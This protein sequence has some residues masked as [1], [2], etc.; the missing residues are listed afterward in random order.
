MSSEDEPGS[1]NTVLVGPGRAGSLARTGPDE[2]LRLS[3]RTNNS[4]PVELRHAVE[5][6]PGVWSQSTL[7]DESPR[8]EVTAPESVVTSDGTL[9]VVYSMVN[10][11]GSGCGLHLATLA[12]GEDEF[13]VRRLAVYGQTPLVALDSEDKLHLAYCSSGTLKYLKQN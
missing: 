5:T 6:S 3:F 7:I 2:P 4:K 1:W 9:H 12:P 13:T 11:I 10:S 8:Y